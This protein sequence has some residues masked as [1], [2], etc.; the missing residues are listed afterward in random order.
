[1][2]APCP[3]QRTAIGTWSFLFAAVFLVT[4][5]LTGEPVIAAAAPQASLGAN[6]E[7][8][9]QLRERIDRLKSAIA[10]TEETRAEARDAL[11]ESERAI[12]EANRQLHTLAQDRQSARVEL[13]RLNVETRR[14]EA[15]LAQRQ[16][17]I[18]RL[19]VVHYEHGE[20][21]YLKL[22]MSG[23]DPNQAT[24]ELHYYGY[25]SRAQADLMKGLR[26]TLAQVRELQDRTREK[27]EEIAR[28]ESE[29]K[30]ERNRLTREQAARRGVLERVSAQLREQRRQVQGLE[31]DEARLTRLI[32]EIGRVIAERAKKSR[33]ERKDKARTAR[34][35]NE[36]DSPGTQALP[37]SGSRVPFASLR[38]SLRLPV[39]GQL[40]SR[41]GSPRPEGG[42]SWK[43]LF[44]RAAPGQEVHAVAPGQVVFAEWMRGFGNL[45]IL[46][47]GAGYLTIYGNNESVLKQVGDNVR[48][49]DAIATTGASGGSTESGLYFEARH[50][51]QPFDPL[52]WVSRK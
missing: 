6:A 42:P 51:G 46:D 12:S 43:G 35:A 19:L 15:E 50:E 17:A 20:T 32:Q 48:T 9:R 37:D 36:P 28:I 7:D 10:G 8:L 3:Q 47:H 30:T 40:V 21:D 29:Q 13:D 2:F 27:T 14:I 52:K 4:L 25:I 5:T 45:L 41:F 1:M 24:R 33:T 22:L 26:T 39:R 31:R 38:G 11:R 49:G 18:G 34:N 16:Q 44:I 23:A